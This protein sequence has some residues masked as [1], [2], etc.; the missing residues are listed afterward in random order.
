MALLYTEIR[1]AIADGRLRSGSRLPATRNIA[2]Q[3]G[4][5]RG[6][7]VAAFNQ[8]K[9]EGYTTHSSMRALMFAPPR[10]VTFPTLRRGSES[11]ADARNVISRTLA[12]YSD[13]PFF[14]PAILSEY[15]SAAMN[16][17]LIFSQLSSGRESQRE[18]CGTLRRSAYGQGD[19][20]GYLPLRRAIA[21]YIG[22]SRGVRC[23][24]DQIMVTAGTQQALDFIARFLVQAGDKV[25][26]EDPGYH[27]ARRTMIAAGVSIVNVPVDRNGM[28]VATAIQKR[29]PQS[30]PT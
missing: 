16:Q 23:T 5:S 21:E 15:P 17:P 10:G 4:I 19:S 28:I 3:Y 7:V 11:R 29:H 20:A 18:S 2:K 27:R 22:R 13:A 12:A 25:W 6:T 1:N 30:W 24:P 8:L 26:M 14:K 9:A